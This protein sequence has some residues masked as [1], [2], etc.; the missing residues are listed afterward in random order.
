[1]LALGTR[2]A[3]QSFRKHGG[4]RPA[5]DG[6]REVNSMASFVGGLVREP[7]SRYPRCLALALVL[8]AALLAACSAA[9]TSSTSELIARPAENQWPDEFFQAS[10]E[11]QEAYRYAV[12]DPGVLQYMPCYCGCGSQG[13]TSAR[14]CF[15]DEVRADGSVVLDRMGFG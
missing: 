12:A 7:C 6:G 2:R 15:V 14:D 4:P 5:G 13:H 8:A 10:L 9:T 1:M 11:V 3:A